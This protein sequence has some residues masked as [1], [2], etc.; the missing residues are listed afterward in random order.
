[1][2]KGRWKIRPTTARRMLHIMQAAGL[3]VD[4]IE[5]KPDG[6]LVFVP[7]DATT[8]GAQPTENQNEWDAA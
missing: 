7:R 3:A 8:I 1:M 2:S 5:A 6:T 4:R